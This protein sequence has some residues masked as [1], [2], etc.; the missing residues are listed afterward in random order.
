MTQ[1]IA[2]LI[3]DKKH[4]SKRALELIAN[5][6]TMTNEILVTE[7]IEKKISDKELQF[8]AAELDTRTKQ[9]VDILESEKKETEQELKKQREKS[10]SKFKSLYNELKDY[11]YILIDKLFTD[12]FKIEKEKINYDLKLNFYK[13]IFFLKRNSEKSKFFF[14]NRNKDNVSVQSDIEKDMIVYNENTVN[15]LELYLY[16]A[17]SLKKALE[18]D[19]NLK[20]NFDYEKIDHSRVYVKVQREEKKES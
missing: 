20:F 14:Q 13:L 10:V 6:D 15:A 16:N 3:I 18:K 7:F 5:I 19:Y 11:K 1:K 17:L 2:E 12:K 8:L 9:K 4:L